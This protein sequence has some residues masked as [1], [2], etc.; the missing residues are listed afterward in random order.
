LNTWVRSRTVMDGWSLWANA[1]LHHAV[2]MEAKS[3]EKQSTF[4][5]PEM[6]SRLE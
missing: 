5:L 6:E 4:E 2:N 1:D 3:A